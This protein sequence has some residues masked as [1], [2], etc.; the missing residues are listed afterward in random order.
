MTSYKETNERL[1]RSSF[2]NYN[3]LDTKLS[4]STAAAQ[5]RSQ[6]RS[7]QEKQSRERRVEFNSSLLLG[8]I[9]TQSISSAVLMS[10]TS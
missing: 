4:I 10:H 9:V 5:V 1:Y 6:I 7:C 8:T 3:M 2:R